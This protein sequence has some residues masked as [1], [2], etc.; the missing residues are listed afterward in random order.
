MARAWPRELADL[1]YA[2]ALAPGGLDGGTEY[3]TIHFDRADLDD[4]DASGARFLECAFTGVSVQG[5]RFRRSRFSDVWLEHARMVLSDFAETQWTD[6]TFIDGTLAGV[7]APGSRLN[8]VVFDGCKLDSVNFRDADLTAVTFSDCLLR[9]AD[10][11]GAALTRTAFT[12][13]RLAGVDFSK[14]RLDQV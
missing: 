11:G 2:A 5:G 6:V 14:A 8:R 13:S 9:E 10:F 12:S 7:L 4:P 1:P 3:D